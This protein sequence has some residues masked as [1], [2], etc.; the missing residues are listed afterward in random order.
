M[1]CIPEVHKITY[2]TFFF[3]LTHCSCRPQGFHAHTNHTQRQFD[4]AEHRNKFEAR[5]A[6]KENKRVGVEESA[7]LHWRDG[8][9]PCTQTQRE[10]VLEPCKHPWDTQN[11][12]HDIFFLDSHTARGVVGRNPILFFNTR[13]QFGIPEVRMHIHTDARTRQM[14]VHRQLTTCDGPK[15]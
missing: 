15:T 3:G 11:Y 6:W 5:W 9:T 7:W 12:V 2:M 14:Y 13:C 1:Q 4:I 10:N 8:L